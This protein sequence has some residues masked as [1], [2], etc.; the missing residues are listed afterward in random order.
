MPS[1]GGYAT[2]LGGRGPLGSLATEHERE[3]PGTR[4]GIVAMVTYAATKLYSVVVERLPPDRGG[5]EDRQREALGAADPRSPPRRAWR[6][7]AATSA[8]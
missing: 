6:Q 7:D 5:G 8:G 3:H 2:G 1:I 4:A